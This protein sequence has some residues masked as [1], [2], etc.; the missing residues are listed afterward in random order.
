MKA[1][2]IAGCVMLSVLCAAP[3]AHAWGCGSSWQ[4]CAY[5]ATHPRTPAF[6][7]GAWKENQDARGGGPLVYGCPH[8]R[9]YLETHR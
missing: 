6:W 9:R 8:C 7:R 1:P 4:I 2:I 5:R 3:R